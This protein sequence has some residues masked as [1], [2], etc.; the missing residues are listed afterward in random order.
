MTSDDELE[1]RSISD[2]LNRSEWEKE[3]REAR[4]LKQAEAEDRRIAEIERIK[5]EI[6]SLGVESDKIFDD[7]YRK[8]LAQKNTEIQEINERI[9]ELE[10]QLKDLEKF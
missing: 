4:E 1:E 2:T 10:K 9:S 7:I 5:K 3:L 6:E 8:D